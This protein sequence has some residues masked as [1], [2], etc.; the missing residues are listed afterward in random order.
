MSLY[1]YRKS[2]RIIVLVIQNLISQ[3]LFLE[4]GVLIIVR[5]GWGNK[6]FMEALC[7]GGSFW[8]IDVDSYYS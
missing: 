5:K 7:N 4:I 2:A 1:S 3:S 8:E 6:L